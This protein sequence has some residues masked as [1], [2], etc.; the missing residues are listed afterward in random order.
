MMTFLVPEPAN[1]DLA[2][3]RLAT[4][5]MLYGMLWYPTLPTTLLFDA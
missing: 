4:L 1:L 5:C 2:Y 3:G